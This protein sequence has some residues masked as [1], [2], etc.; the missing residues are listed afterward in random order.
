MSPLHR[1]WFGVALKLVAALVV[2]G[3]IYVVWRFWIQPYETQ[4][5][6]TLQR[7]GN[8]APLLFI[9]VFLL[10][11]L[12][13]FPESILAIVAGTIFGLWWGLLWVVI[14]GTLTAAVIFFLGRRV[15]RTRVE[16]L[17]AA[18]PKVKAIDDAASQRGFKLAFLLRLAP[19][20]FAMLNLILSVSRIR[21]RV[22]LLSCVGMFPGNFSTV[23]LGFAARHTADLA[24]CMKQGHAPA[25]QGNGLVHE[26]SLYLGLGASLLC[27]LIVAKIAMNAVHAAALKQPNQQSPA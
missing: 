5:A 24:Q 10:A 6:D 4:L 21:F 18:H 25:L 14:A 8:W 23:Y 2:L 11:T 16:H 19:V 13:F 3:A 17:L 7:I 27:S 22:Y 9:G 12:L 26:V 15:L 20:S 1:N